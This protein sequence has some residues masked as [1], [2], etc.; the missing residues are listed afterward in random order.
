M[1]FDDILEGK[2]T[3]QYQK[4]EQID[5]NLEEFSKMAHLANSSVFFSPYFYMH[6][7]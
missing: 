4:Q 2:K 7:C 1:K 3:L 5:E 6:I